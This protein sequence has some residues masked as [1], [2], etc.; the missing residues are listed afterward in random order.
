[1]R[2][3]PPNPWIR[4]TVSPGSA[5]KTVIAIV[6]SMVAAVSVLAS[7]L[8]VS[9]PIGQIRISNRTAANRM[10]FQTGRLTPG[11]NAPPTAA[12]LEAVAANGVTLREFIGFAYL[13]EKGALTRTQVIGGPEWADTV[14]FDLIVPNPSNSMAA[15]TRDSDQVTIGGATIP[16]LQQML[17]EHFQLRVHKEQRT[18]PALSLVK[19][20]T[21]GPDLKPSTATCDPV[22]TAQRCD[23]RATPG[24]IIVRG[25]T[26][27]HLAMQ[28]SWNFPALQLPVVD[29]SGIAGKFDYT[30]SYV[31]ALLNAPN[32]KDPF[33]PNPSAGSGLSLQQALEQRLGLKLVEA[34]ETFDVVV[35]DSVQP[36]Q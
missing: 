26:M 36:L 29:K 18:L 1:M 30:L 20:E 9:P 28:L 10:W 16:L 5:V 3:R 25:M 23:F 27:R 32:P 35:I 34:K 33:I 22:D 11:P 19:G 17:A 13:N 31:P 21:A 15:L 14:R 24:I 12:S 2:T 6:G 4:F 7:Q 8:P